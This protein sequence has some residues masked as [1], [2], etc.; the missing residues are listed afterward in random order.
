MH[1]NVSV[2]LEIWIVETVYDFAAEKNQRHA[3][4]IFIGMLMLITNEDPFCDRDAL[5][6]I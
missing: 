5:W 3:I 1:R 2:H 4:I 6:K